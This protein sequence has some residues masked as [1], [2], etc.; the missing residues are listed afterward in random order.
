M[1]VRTGATEVERGYGA[2]SYTDSYCCRLLHYSRSM[3]RSVRFANKFRNLSL[4][5]E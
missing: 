3:A 5:S 4:R 1:S 2:Y